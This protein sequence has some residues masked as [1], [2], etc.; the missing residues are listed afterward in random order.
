MRSIALIALAGLAEAMPAL[1]AR[2]PRIVT[3]T[4]W[5]DVFTTVTVPYGAPTNVAHHV[6]GHAKHTQSTSSVSSSVQAPVP[7][8]TPV[9]QTTDAPPPPPV[10]TT[11]QA[12][13]PPPAQATTDSPAP[14]AAPT[15]PP[16]A[17]AAAPSDNSYS[18]LVLYHHNVHRQNHSAPDMTW[19][20]SL[21]DTAM[22]IAQSCSYAHNTAMDGGGYGQNIAAGAP[23]NNIAA[24]ITDQFYNGE[25]NYFA[26][27]Y[28]QATP[29]DFDA[30]F[31]H[32]GHMTQ[33]VWVGSTTVGCASYDCST[34]GGLANVGSN[35]PPVFHVCNYGPAGKFFH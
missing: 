17:V 19:S 12:P 15:N 33:V 30:D 11:T 22:K 5:V 32:Y 27:D 2:D 20:Q 13:P 21:A 4:D 29:A 24:V 9:Q 8:N 3:V 10:E 18:G 23:V 35:V 14:V 34:H 25:I 16:V 1:V 7:A 6:G 26:N 31:E 28:G